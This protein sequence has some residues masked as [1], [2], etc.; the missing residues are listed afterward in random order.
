MMKPNVL[1]V[2][3]FIAVSGFVLVWGA[4]AVPIGSVGAAQRPNASEAAALSPNANAGG[5]APSETES[6]G[7]HVLYNGIRLP[8]VWPPREQDFPEDP[9]R[10][11]YLSSP[12]AVI[13]IDVGRQ[14]FVDDFLI[15]QTTLARTFHRPRYAADNPVLKPDRPWEMAN[16]KPYAMPFS[17]GVWWDPRDR[18]FKLWYYA[19][20]SATCYATSA[21]G[22]HW[23]KPPLDVEPGTNV[24]FRGWRDSSTVW[25]DP[26]PRE[27][28]ERFKMAVYQG[29]FALYRSADGIHWT[30]AADGAKTGD[31]STFFYNPFRER[32]VF[33]IR[34][35]SRWG[36]SRRY[37]ETTDFFAFADTPEVKSETVAWVASD[38]ADP[39][40][41]DL[42]ARPQLYN[43]DCVAYE[44]VLLG[45]FS[46][47]RGDYRNP[48]TDEARRLL[49]L[50]RPKQNSVCVGFSRDGFH[51]DRP[52]RQPF[53]P[54]SEQMGDWNWGNVQSTVPCCLVVGDEL[55]FYVSG[56][57]GK[58]FPGA[59][60]LDSGASL[61]LARLR[62][63]GFVSRDA[64]ADGG[65]LTT[66]PIR[67]HG[68]HLF[69][70]LDA[71]EGELRV[72]VLDSA[73]QPLPPFDR[74]RCPAI[75]GDSTR[76]RVVWDEAPDLS[77]V[78]GQP[79]RLRFHLTAGKLYSF[80]VT[81]DPD[82]ASYGYVAG[83]GP[84]FSGP[85]DRP[86]GSRT[87]EA[88]SSR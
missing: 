86:N 58:S 22:I 10:P 55:W 36:R 40:R 42:R 34:S 63:D 25:L 8:D 15:E 2:V 52:D 35:N 69:V 7:Y 79:V 29:N 17:D 71:P 23:N 21:D 84:G 80:W 18:C 5:A 66:R 39:P 83:G 3:N 6:A 49:E 41:D 62:R 26:E 37:W 67:F 64:D 24:V 74:R 81:P 46:I 50:G 11:P 85:L 87:T 38:S 9:Q 44:S 47:W 59:Q 32:W 70:N 30:K 33:S 56:R 68:R 20:S 53:L 72:E 16:G 51:W 76:Q 54:T 43:L 57:A 19:G 88:S 4:V 27:A 31:R 73:G 65:T 12:P 77:A 45:L 1:R 28:S 82:G 14:L 61:G 60:H 78:A 13:P 75:R 48:A